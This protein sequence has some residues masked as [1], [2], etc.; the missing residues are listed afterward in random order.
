MTEH[1]NNLIGDPVFPADEIAPPI[2]P[3]IEARPAPDAPMVDHALYYAACG[4][5]VFPAPFGEKKSHKSAARS[6]GRNP[7]RGCNT[8]HHHSTFLCACA[9][10]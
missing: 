8:L 2:A 4:W 5:H 1:F 7:I 10:P 9:Q 3:A 6:G